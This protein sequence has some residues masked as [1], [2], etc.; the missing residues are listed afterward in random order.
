MVLGR[1]ACKRYFQKIKSWRVEIKPFITLKL[2]LVILN[3]FFMFW[4]S[5]LWFWCVW[6]WQHQLHYSNPLS[7][8]PSGTD[9]FISN[10]KR[11]Y[12]GWV[13]DKYFCFLPYFSQ[14]GT[15]VSCL[16]RVFCLVLMDTMVSTNS[17]LVSYKT[18]MRK[19]LSVVCPSSCV[20]MLKRDIF[21]IHHHLMRLLKR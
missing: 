4:G 2:N 3:P 20:S 12:A 10:V 21:A 15:N 13:W 19:W 1:R 11:I 18:G 8:W 9:L 17:S 14:V 5:D 6:G 16:F 7:Q